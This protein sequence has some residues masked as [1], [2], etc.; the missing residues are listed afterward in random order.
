VKN[1]STLLTQFGQTQQDEFKKV[2]RL[3]FPHVYFKLSLI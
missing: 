2:K 3:Y 1:G